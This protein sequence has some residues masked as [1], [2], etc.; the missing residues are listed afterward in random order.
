[1]FQDTDGSKQLILFDEVREKVRK[2]ND[3]LTSLFNFPSSFAELRTPSNCFFNASI[4]DRFSS[5]SRQVAAN[6]SF[7]SLCFD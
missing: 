3:A 1:M 2:M 5:S 7:V 6:K 4:A